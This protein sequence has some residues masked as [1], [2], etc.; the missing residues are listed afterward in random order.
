MNELIDLEV[1]EISLTTAGAN[2]EADVLI[3]KS[4]AYG[5]PDEDPELAAAKK[6]LTDVMARKLVTDIQSAKTPYELSNAVRCCMDAMTYK[7]KALSAEGEQ[8]T[9]QEIAKLQ[10]DLK[11]ATER[12]E[13]AEKENTDLKATIAKSQTPEDIE[14]AKLAALPADIRKRLED[15]ESEIKKMRDASETATYVAKAAELKHLPVKAEE[16][17]PILKSASAGLTADQKTELD[18]VLK[19]ADAALAAGFRPVGKDSVGG[20]DGKTQFMAKVDELTK[21][22]AKPGDAM[23]KA[24]QENPEL[25][26][27]YRAALTVRG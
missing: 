10:G 2:P 12:A 6:Q 9:E 5:M 4:E 23:A 21:A 7:T 3:F 24:A 15:T 1:S 20:G 13:K 25:Y 16:F 17:G 14:K 19:A 26:N 27:E 18:R 22:G 8:M 11:T